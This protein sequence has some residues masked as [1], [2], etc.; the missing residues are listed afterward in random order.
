MAWCFFS[1]FLGTLLSSRF[2][3]DLEAYSRL[4]PEALGRHGVYTFGIYSCGGDVYKFTKSFA[5]R[6][7]SSDHEFFVCQV[8]ISSSREVRFAQSAPNMSRLE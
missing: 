5:H 3:L 6:T 1:C 2:S 8:P 7:A 4:L